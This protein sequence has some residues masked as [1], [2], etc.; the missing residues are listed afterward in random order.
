MIKVLKDQQEPAF[1]K[2]REAQQVRWQKMEQSVKFKENEEFK[3]KAREPVTK[4]AV[5]DEEGYDDA[6]EEEVIESEGDEIIE[7]YYV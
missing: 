1:V 3:P 5:S 4:P 7:D 2:I 6:F